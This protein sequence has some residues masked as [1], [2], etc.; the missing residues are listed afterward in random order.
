MKKISVISDFVKCIKKAVDF[1]NLSPF[2]GFDGIIE[3]QTN[4]TILLESGCT[5]SDKNNGVG[6][7]NLKPHYIGIGNII[8][9]H[10]SL[11][12]KIPREIR[13]HEKLIYLNNFESTLADENQHRYTALTI[14]ALD[15]LDLNN[16]YVADLGSADGILCLLANKKGAKSI[17][18]DID[19]ECENQF[20]KHIEVNNMNPAD[21]QFIVAD[22]IDKGLLSKKLPTEKIDVVVANLGPHYEDADISASALLEYLPHAK[23]FIGGGYTE[24]HN[25]SAVNRYSPVEALDLLE[26][27]GFKLWKKIKESSVQSPP[28][29]T[30]IVKRLY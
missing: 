19:R 27:K 25:N 28:R 29:L 24:D 17:A 22:I 16:K 12:S 18:V 9:L 13:N 15:M 2:P 21:F 14:H 23:V 30:F 8:F 3:D 6:M 26:R 1:G 5:L 4:R 10:H 7:K 11:K 20:K